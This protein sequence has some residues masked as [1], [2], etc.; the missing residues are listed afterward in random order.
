MHACNTR[1]SN[2]VHIDDVR[3]SKVHNSFPN[4]GIKMFNNLSAKV[5]ELPKPK[6]Y[7]MLKSWLLSN[8]MYRP[9]EF[10]ETQVAL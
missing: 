5:R 2:N 3:M 7:G 1:T 4:S 8:P 6:F 10:Y 9:E